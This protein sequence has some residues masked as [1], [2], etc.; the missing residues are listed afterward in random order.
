M[1][2][3]NQFLVD[4]KKASSYESFRARFFRFLNECWSRK[5]FYDD[6]DCMCDLIYEDGINQQWLFRVYCALFGNLEFIPNGV[7][8]DMRFRLYIAAIEKLLY[9]AEDDIYSSDEEKV[10]DAEKIL[11]F[12]Y[13]FLQVRSCWWMFSH[14]FCDPDDEKKQNGLFYK[15]FTRVRS[16][17]HLFISPENVVDLEGHNYCEILPN[18]NY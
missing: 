7:E 8:R 6:F 15:F 18:G 10:K 17:P 5:T 14:Q 13:S 11:G 12:F 1:D 2:F 9:S 16:Y 4:I 3:F